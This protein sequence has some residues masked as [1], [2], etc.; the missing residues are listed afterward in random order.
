MSRTV[1]FQSWDVDDK[2][3]A[4]IKLHLAPFLAIYAGL[5]KQKGLQ[6]IEVETIELSQKIKRE[7]PPGRPHGSLH[8]KG[9]EVRHKGII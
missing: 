3:P 9:S 8:F 7:M 2:K 4:R 6:N 1:V 5:I